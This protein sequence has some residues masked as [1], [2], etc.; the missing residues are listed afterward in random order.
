[1]A[2]PLPFLASPRR[3]R[4][5]RMASPLPATSIPGAVRRAATVTFRKGDCRAARSLPTV[6]TAPSDRPV[7]ARSSPV[8]RFEV[9]GAAGGGGGSVTWLLPS[10]CARRGSRSGRQRRAKK[11]I[12]ESP[13][14]SPPCT[15]GHGREKNWGPAPLRAR[16]R[17]DL[18]LVGGRPLRFRRGA[19]RGPR[20]DPSHGFSPPF[21]R[22]G[23]YLFRTSLPSRFLN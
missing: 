22:D 8:D 1:M 14:W 4:I 23:S 10:L 16:K 20:A 19:F 6:P 12:P 11:R 3:W 7:L 5:R 17:P 2:S 13:G 15:G 9:R 21:P 18:R